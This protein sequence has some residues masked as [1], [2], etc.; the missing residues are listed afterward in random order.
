M[1]AANV[2]V[3]AAMLAGC[4]GGT[5]NVAKSAVP[6]LKHV[7]EYVH[8]V[9]RLQPTQTV[10]TLPVPDPD[11]RPV[12]GQA[13]PNLQWPS[14]FQEYG[15]VL[16]DPKRPGANAVQLLMFGNEELPRRVLGV[17]NR[18]DPRVLR[19]PTPGIWRRVGQTL[20]IWSSAP[21]PKQ[22][23]AVGDCLA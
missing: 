10:A 18:R 19:F 3:L 22:R 21:T 5:T 6:C 2:V 20:V 4:G 8:H 16:F 15:E 23:T 17:H 13:T 14:D 7:G 11:A 1:R 12:V 9:K